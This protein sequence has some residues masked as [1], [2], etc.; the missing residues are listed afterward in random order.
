LALVWWFDKDSTAPKKKV[1]NKKQFDDLANKYRT[2]QR[3]VDQAM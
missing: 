3:L 2:T 1:D